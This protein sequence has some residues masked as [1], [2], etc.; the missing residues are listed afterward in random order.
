MVSRPSPDYPPRRASSRACGASHIA[1]QARLT[2]LG[3]L[4]Q[5]ELMSEAQNPY[6]RHLAAGARVVANTLRYA[7]VQRSKLLGWQEPFADDHLM[8]HY[9]YLAAWNAVLTVAHALDHL[10]KLLPKGP[11][12][13]GYGTMVA[14]VPCAG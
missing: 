1:R 10:R 11:S 4:Q 8:Y 12:C 5:L 9:Q 2:S 6:V 14:H 13:G 3:I 7:H